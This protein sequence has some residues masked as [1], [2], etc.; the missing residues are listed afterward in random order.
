MIRW[1]I[2]KGGLNRKTGG[3]KKKNQNGV[4]ASV[5]RTKLVFAYWG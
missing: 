4:M 5:A 3:L 2:K 1:N